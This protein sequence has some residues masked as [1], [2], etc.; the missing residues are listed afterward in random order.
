MIFAEH[1][2]EDEDYEVVLSSD[3]ETDAVYSETPEGDQQYQHH[4]PQQQRQHQQQHQQQHADDQQIIVKTLDEM[5]LKKSMKSYQSAKSEL[6]SQ[7]AGE[8]SLT[9]MI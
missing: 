2:T 5:H 4:L 8:F 1:V 6:F 7:N 9:I 3:E